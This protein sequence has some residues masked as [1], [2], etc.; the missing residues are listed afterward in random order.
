MF[1]HQ[2]SVSTNGFTYDFTIKNPAA[3]GKYYWI[4]SE[5]N[6]IYARD[7]KRGGACAGSG[8]QVDEAKHSVNVT[9]LSKSI[10]VRQKD[11]SSVVCNATIKCILRLI[12]N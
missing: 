8:A 9:C 12:V 5:N 7:V 10:A 1:V 11:R 3:G 4:V 2:D 6:R